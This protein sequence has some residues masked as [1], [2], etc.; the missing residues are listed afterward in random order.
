MNPDLKS[1]CVLTSDLLP[2]RLKTPRTRLRTRAAARPLG[3]ATRHP[4]PPTT[5][6]PRRV[7]PRPE[8]GSRGP[9]EA[10]RP[11]RMGEPEREAEP[12][13]TVSRRIARLEAG[14]TGFALDGSEMLNF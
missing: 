13:A 14:Q 1:G 7:A 5:G 3:G 9:V 11:G 2:S 8:E 12:G 4:A 6:W 10:R